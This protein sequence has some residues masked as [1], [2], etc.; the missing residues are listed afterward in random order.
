MAR[1]YV[2]DDHPL[3]G[4]RHFQVSI[5]LPIGHL[6]LQLLAVGFW[7]LAVTFCFQERAE[8]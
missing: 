7:T 4:L 2:E 8:F 5:G 1:Q 6:Q 3:L